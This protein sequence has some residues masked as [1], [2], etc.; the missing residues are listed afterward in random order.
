MRSSELARLAGVTVRTLRHY[1]RTGILPEPERSHNG[2]REYRVEDLIRLIRTARLRELGLSLAEI[3][4]LLDDREARAETLQRAEAELDAEI[5]RLTKRRDR[6]SR[7]REDGLLPELGPLAEAL[8][9]SGESLAS[10]VDLDG[11]ELEQLVIFGHL[12]PPEQVAWL[13][14]AHTELLAVTQTASHDPRDVGTRFLA[15]PADAPPEAWDALLEDMLAEHGDF[16]R[17]LVAQTAA[18]DFP[19]QPDLSRVL[20]GHLS[21]RLS[22]GLRDTLDRF[23]AAVTQEPDSGPDGSREGE[24]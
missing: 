13:V 1:H 20:T 17:D 23:L 5:A 18:E 10:L 7:L 9:P 2:Y 12:A 6:V 22:P 3:Q 8:D 16:F 4:P 15:F 24:P 19:E 11:T 21:E 14:R